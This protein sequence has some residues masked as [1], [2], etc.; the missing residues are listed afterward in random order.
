MGRFAQMAKSEY[1]KSPDCSRADDGMECETSSLGDQSVLVYCVE[2]VSLVNISRGV[3]G[4]DVGVSR[5]QTGLR[6]F[7]KFHKVHV[8]TFRDSTIIS[9]NH[10]HSRSST[11]VAKV[12][13]GFSL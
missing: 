4:P 5:E 9:P 3:A 12:Y 2:V 13:P 11:L 8:F 7:K 10:T 6:N 1:L